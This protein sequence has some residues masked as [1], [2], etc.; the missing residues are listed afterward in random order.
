M[1]GEKGILFTATYIDKFYEMEQKLKKPKRTS[2]INPELQKERL[3]IQK[4]KLWIELSKGAIGTYSDMCKTM[5][6]TH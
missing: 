1:T 6:L 5:Q 2:K 4:A 3:A